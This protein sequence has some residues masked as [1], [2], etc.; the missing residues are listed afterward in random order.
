MFLQFTYYIEKCIVEAEN[1]E[2]RTAILMRIIE[3][4]TVLRELNNF[5]G[6]FEVM[7]ALES[8]SVHRLEHTIGRIKSNKKLKATYDE[9]LDLMADHYKKYEFYRAFLKILLTIFTF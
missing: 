9:G 3:V 4:A 6:V 5:N 2:E 8:A 1:F 7:S